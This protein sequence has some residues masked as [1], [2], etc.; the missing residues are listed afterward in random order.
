MFVLLFATQTL[1]ELYKTNLYVMFWL[2]LY[3]PIQQVQLECL[4][5]ENTPALSPWTNFKL[6]L[7]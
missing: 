2:I 6:G 3:S 4:R 7:P 1:S 5:S